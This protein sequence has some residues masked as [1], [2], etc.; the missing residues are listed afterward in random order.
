MPNNYL[1]IPGPTPVPH[2]VAQAMSTEMFNHRGP[3]FAELLLN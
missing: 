2:A 1:L 3:R